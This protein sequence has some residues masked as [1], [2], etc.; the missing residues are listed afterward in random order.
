MYIRFFG[1]EN[2]RGSV[3]VRQREI[4]RDICSVCESF[5]PPHTQ[6]GHQFLLPCLE[7]QHKHT[8]DPHD[9]HY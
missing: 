2:G 7:N 3:C 6:S 1:I 8:V 5:N 9:L 4:E